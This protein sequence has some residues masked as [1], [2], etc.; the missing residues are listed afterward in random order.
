MVSIMLCVKGGLAGL[1]A[2]NPFHKVLFAHFGLLG[3]V[4][5]SRPGLDVETSIPNPYETNQI[6]ST[7]PSLTLKS[8]EVF[9]LM[10]RSNKAIEVFWANLRDRQ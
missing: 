9:M 10:S 6:S 4:N 3:K 7:M 2:R 5:R 8:H 1:P